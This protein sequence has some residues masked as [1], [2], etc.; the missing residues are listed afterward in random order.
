MRVTIQHAS[1][2]ATLMSSSAAPA[3]APPGPPAAAPQ[4]TL[5]SALSSISPLT[6]FLALPTIPC[7]RSSLLFGIAAGLA[8]GSTR[9]AFSRGIARTVGASAKNASANA[10]G[11]KGKGV[12]GNGRWGD[13]G[14]ASNWA[15]GAFGLSSLAAWYVHPFMHPPHPIQIPISIAIYHRAVLYH[16]P[17]YSAP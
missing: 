16:A 1:H 14:S 2:P 4:S 11:M 5:S 8:V 10:N 9:Y 7:A 6:D 15:V 13:V 12:D 17:L 3:A